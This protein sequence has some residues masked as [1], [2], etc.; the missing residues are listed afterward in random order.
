VHALLLEVDRGRR[1]DVAWEGAAAGLEERDRAWAHAALFGTLR[2]RGRIDHLLGLHLHHGSASVPVPL[3]HVL[4]LGAYELLEMGS[5][6]DFAAVSQAVGLAREVGG[7][8]A[9]GLVN[10]V[11]RALAA[12]GGGQDRF[13]AFGK[14]P[15]A[16]LSTW[17]S[18]P[19]WLVER[20]VERW[21]PEGAR[22]VVEAGN[23]IPDLFLRPIEKSREEAIDDLRGRG[24]LAA[25]GP[26]GT[27]TV[28][29]PAGVDPTA[30]LRATRG[31]IQDPAAS[32][33]V[34]FIGD[35][36]GATVADLCAAPGGKGVALAG[37][38]A[39][40]VGADLAHR[41]LL[42][43]RDALRRLGLAE[44]LVVARAEA[45][46][47]VEMDVVLVDA[48]C[49][50]TGTLARHPDARW[51]LSPR[52]PEKLAGVQGRILAGASRC[53]RPGGRLVYATCTL[54]SEENEGVVETFLGSHPGFAFEAASDSLGILPGEIGTDGAFAARMRRVT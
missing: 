30:A 36:S 10:A 28:R 38:G 54:E 25:P 14:D 16:H 51:R 22:E 13:P 11:L 3:L 46:P 7:A 32:S 34:E 23:R 31:I 44:R 8:K 37:I 41:R 15:V 1:L 20:W 45:P 4:R 17:G 18:H 35:V 29:L 33:V 52:D 48:P 2:L 53:V 43:M 42:R 12:E 9:A 40:V 27:Q 39:R 5:V 47:F 6:P 21:G 26:E 19:R 49:S 50:G 24:I